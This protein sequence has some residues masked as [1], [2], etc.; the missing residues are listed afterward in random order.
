MD[1]NKYNN[2]DR[3]DFLIQSAGAVAAAS[4]LSL[5]YPWANKASA[6][7]RVKNVSGQL[8]ILQ[9]ASSK[10]MAQFTIDLP[11][12]QITHVQVV[13]KNGDLILPRKLTS[14]SR[15]HSPWRV[16]KAI[17]NGLQLGHEYQLQVL[18]E[19]EELI[20][21]RSFKT[22]NTDNLNPKVAMM[23]CMRYTSSRVK[24]MWAGVPVH[25][26]DLLLFLGDNVYGDK[27]G[28]PSP[29]LLWRRYID[30]RQTIPFYHNYELLPVV[31]IWDD[32]DFGKNNSEGDYEHAA[33]A[34]LTFNAFFPQE[35]GFSDN[36][37]RGP[38]ISTL[39][40]AFNTE[41]AFLDGRTF[42]ESSSQTM[43]GDAQ[44]DWYLNNK[45][46]KHNWILSGSQ[47]FGGYRKKES[48][49]IIAPEEFKSMITESKRLGT[50]SFAA[51]DVH[52][53]EI[54]D[55]DEDDLKLK[56]VELT[57][58]SMHSITR[59]FSKK[60]PRRR[61]SLFKQ[62]W[63]LLTMNAKNG[64]DAKVEVIQKRGKVR[65]TDHIGIA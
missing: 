54:M 25:K 31:A 56:T 35:A 65:H 55:I 5:V 61:Y 22:L 57:S 47:F 41:F 38:G 23:S 60:N 62:N 21:Y 33:D 45:T 29:E 44:L 9:G 2:L 52:Y 46:S 50:I 20:D 14:E 53:S 26:P 27:S 36:V 28:D 64:L 12:D 17:F 10:E 32:H 43:M 63:M 37:L 11:K 7:P 30:T 58:S 39:F 3:R 1:G 34:A 49:D 51:G 15:V 4:A 48:Y 8:S 59:P 16:D 6:K 19:S 24:K 40:R 42:R 18:N 13:T